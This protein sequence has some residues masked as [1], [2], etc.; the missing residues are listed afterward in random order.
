MKHAMTKCPHCGHESY[1][2]AH[3][4]V[5]QIAE[6]CQQ[7]GKMFSHDMRSFAS[8]ANDVAEK[9]LKAKDPFALAKELLSQL[10]EL[11]SGKELADARSSGRLAALKRYGLVPKNK[12]EW[13]V[14]VGVALAVIKYLGARP[15]TEEKGPPPTP[16]TIVN[17]YINGVESKTP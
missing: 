3:D 13:A 2:Q 14:V 6:K 8:M 4:G 17:V 9:I 16:Q 1:T 5:L 10:E 15:A 7:C 12:K 11:K